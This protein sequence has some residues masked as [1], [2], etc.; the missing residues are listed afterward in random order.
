MIENN[1]VIAVMDTPGKEILNPYF[2]YILTCTGGGVG[3]GEVVAVGA[4]QEY[5]YVGTGLTSFHYR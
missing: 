2:N 5:A 1:N 3:P 4:V